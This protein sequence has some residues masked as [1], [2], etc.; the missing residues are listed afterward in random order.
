LDFNEMANHTIS[1]SSTT[2]DSYLAKRSLLEQVTKRRADFSGTLLDIGCGDMPYKALLTREPS[3]ISRYLGLDL[4]VNDYSKAGVDLFWDGR[5]IPLPDES[6]DCA[7]ATEVLEHCPDPTSVLKETLRVLRPGGLL[8]VTVPFLWPLHDVPHDE[9]RYT[10]FALTRH[11]EA[12]GYRD[13]RL[14]ALGG[15]DASLG[16]MIGLWVRRRPM[17]K[18]LRTILSLLA[19]PVVKVLIALD[20]P[21][22]PFGERQM[23]TGLA[24]T[25]K[26]PG[27]Q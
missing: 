8:F 21:P 2:L 10:P 17:R 16:Q 25:A 26:K 14:E 20:R 27:G 1:F 4:A 22:S 15:W 5:T 6:V 23:I 18:S 12:A 19:A 24:G 11:L 9:Y 7:I 3:R 13:V